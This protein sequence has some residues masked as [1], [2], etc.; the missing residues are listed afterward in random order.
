MEVSVHST[1]TKRENKNDKKLQFRIIGFS[2]A[3][4]GLF[5]T[6]AAG[7]NLRVEQS[8]LCRELSPKSDLGTKFRALKKSSKNP[9]QI[10]KGGGLEV[11]SG[12]SFYFQ[13]K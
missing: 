9:T 11:S 1:K 6:L 12:G 10:D 7:S 2:I 13:G 8:A 3:R 4:V 5:Q